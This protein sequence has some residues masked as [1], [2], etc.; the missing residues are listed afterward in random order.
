MEEN[1]KNTEPKAENLE[2]MDFEQS[3][4]ETVTVEETRE[5]EPTPS[6]N[7][8]KEALDWVVSIAVAIVIALVIKTYVFTLVRV[9]GPSMNPTLTNGDVL[10]A[11]RFMYKPAVGDIIIFRPPNSPKTPY[12]KRVI[13][14]GGQTV[15]VNGQEH[16]VTVDGK[17]LDEEYIAAP[18]ESSGTMEYPCT[19][20][21]G[22]IFVM[23]DN[24][25]NSRDSRDA[26]VGLIPLGNV[27]GKAEFRLLP[28]ADFGSLY[29]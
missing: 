21:E 1:N 8:K 9:D 27:I 3:Q 26:T 14:V 28:F 19:V 23:G 2:Q 24:R 12:I 25:N 16:T 11:N 17:V 7:W 13:A 29:K 20:P 22:Y 10:Y 4:N 15:E 18:L 5:P 6:F